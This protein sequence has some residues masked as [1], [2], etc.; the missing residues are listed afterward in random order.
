MCVYSTNYDGRIVAVKTVLIDC[1]KV[2][3]VAKC[4]HVSTMTIYNW[5]KKYKKDIYLK[6]NSEL[7]N[8]DIRKRCLNE[9]V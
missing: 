1:V 4:F 9:L 2:K 3:Y 8:I 6:K 5:I 7:L